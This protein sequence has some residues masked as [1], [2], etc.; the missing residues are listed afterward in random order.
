MNLLK[1]TILT[2]ACAGT[3]NAWKSVGHLLVARI[4]HDILETESPDTITKVESI[5][6]P[7][8]KDFPTWTTKEGNHPFVECTTY[9]DDIKYKGGSF[10]SPWHF[11]DEPYLD[12]GGTIA[13][14]N[15]TIPPHNNTEAV[16]AIVNMFNKVSGYK[17]TYIYK[18]LI[19]HGPSGH[20]DIDSISNAMRFLIHYVGDA[21]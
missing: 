11:D 3:A 10:Q 6:K 19:S 9:A 2:A 14:F 20:S 15:Y 7:M 21:H 17:D 12:E 1:T 18:S 13:D 8:Q 16:D 5:L 4:A